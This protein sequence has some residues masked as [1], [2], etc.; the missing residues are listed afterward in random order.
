MEINS[1]IIS[2][3][4][5]RDKKAFE[6]VYNAYY[7]LVFYI[8]FNITKDEQLSLD[9][10]QDTFVNLMSNIENY[11]DN[12]RLKQYITTIASNLSRNALKKK[13]NQNALLDDNKITAYSYE[14]NTKAEILATLDKYLSPEEKNIVILKVLFD[15]TF[16]EIAYETNTTIG[17]VQSTYYRAMETLKNYF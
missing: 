1:A 14:D 2:K 4:R 5:H 13:D 7:K 16:N 11:F 8:A 10:M 15:Y 6:E 12:G 9:I 17:V 3:L